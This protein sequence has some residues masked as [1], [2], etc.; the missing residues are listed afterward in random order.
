MRNA[1]D[2]KSKEGGRKFFQYSTEYDATAVKAVE[3]GQLSQRQTCKK[4]KI[5]RSTLHNRLARMFTGIFDGQTVFSKEEEDIFT[6]HLLEHS[7]CGFPVDYLDLRLIAKAY[8]DKSNRIVL[9][10]A[11]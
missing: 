4:Y 5:P 6:A 7:E 10:P 1:T 11:K 3:D 2:V 8:L 9:K